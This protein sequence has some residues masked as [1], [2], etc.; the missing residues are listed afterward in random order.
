MRNKFL[1]GLIVVGRHGHTILVS[2][3]SLDTRNLYL[4]PAWCSGQAQLLLLHDMLKTVLLLIT[5]FPGKSYKTHSGLFWACA[6]IVES[7]YTGS[8]GLLWL[9]S[10]CCLLLIGLERDE[11]IFESGD[12]YVLGQEGLIL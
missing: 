2:G 12:G 9:G 8:E 10:G 3:F 6:W 5:T 11:Y 4:Y 1:I 7:P